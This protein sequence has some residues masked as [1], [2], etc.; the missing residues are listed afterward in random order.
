MA[1][2]GL[3]DRT[4]DKD[5]EIHHKRGDTRVGTLR[6]T[7]GADFAAGARSD[8]HLSTV[9]ARAGV[10]TLSQYLKQQKRK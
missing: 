4:R 7:Y 1:T 10:D 6:E 2:K 9:L 8:A 3:D 5:G